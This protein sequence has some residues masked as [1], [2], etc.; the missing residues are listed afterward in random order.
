MQHKGKV[1]LG[2]GREHARRGKALVV[3][4]GGVVA[5]DPLHRVRRVGDDGIKGLVVAK[6]RG[7]Q[8]VA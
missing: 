4:Q 2:L 5:A 1:G 8:G 3:D 7:D 6:M